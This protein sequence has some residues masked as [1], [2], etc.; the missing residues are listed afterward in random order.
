MQLRD[1]GT[2]DYG[3]TQVRFL[4]EALGL[5]KMIAGDIVLTDAQRVRAIRTSKGWL[6]LAFTLDASSR[7]NPAHHCR[8]KDGRQLDDHRPAS[9]AP[10]RHG[11]AR[12]R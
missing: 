10:A 4:N 8:E 1:P 5:S 2:S 9:G 6:Y 7:R 12:A 11:T 3:L